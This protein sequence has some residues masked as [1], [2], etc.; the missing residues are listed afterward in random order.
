MTAAAVVAPAHGAEQGTLE[1]HMKR[2]GKITASRMNDLMALN[3]RTGAPL[4]A[5]ATYRDEILT[6]RLT[7]KVE[8]IPPNYAM[9]W[10][11]LYEPAA[12]ARYAQVRKLR[13]EQVDFVEHPT[14]PFVGASPDGVIGKKKGGA[15]IKC[16]HNPRVHLAT[17]RD[18]MPLAH[19]GQVQGNL[20]I[21]EAE[22]W[23][24]VSYHPL[25]PEGLDIFI[26][27]VY[28]DDDY[29]GDLEAQCV[30]LDAEVEADM[31]ALLK[32]KNRIF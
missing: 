8:I 32:I 12:R 20:W 31:A 27:R 11:N 16:P 24:F 18:G 13:V 5:R 22:W 15:E 30:L 23:D 2:A 19:T 29:I 1:W 6:E 10:G 28:R 7:G 25:F 3:T 14:L 4:A 9:K 17:L 26:Q 21:N